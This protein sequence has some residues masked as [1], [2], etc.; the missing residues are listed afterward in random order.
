LE[1]IIEQL[2]DSI[3]IILITSA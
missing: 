2:K 3:R 1:I